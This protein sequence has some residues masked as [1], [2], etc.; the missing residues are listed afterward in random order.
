MT[1]YQPLGFYAVNFFFDFRSLTVKKEIV[2]HFP[3]IPERIRYAKKP[4][5]NFKSIF[6]PTDTLVA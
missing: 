2:K 1:I 3:H 5:Q 4:V 6:R